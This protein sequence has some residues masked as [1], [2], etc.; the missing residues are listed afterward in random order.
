MSTR[1][2]NSDV[3]TAPAMQGATNYRIYC[4]FKGKTARLGR[5]MYHIS[6]NLAVGRREKYL[7]YKKL[8]GR[9]KGHKGAQKKCR[10]YFLFTVD[11]Y[12]F[13]GA[14]QKSA[15]HKSITIVILYII[16]DS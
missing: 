12:F 14:P 9:Q 7:G 10:P 1:P 5:K 16:W 4:F 15:R 6:V 3:T 11:N 13:V 2:H 8:H